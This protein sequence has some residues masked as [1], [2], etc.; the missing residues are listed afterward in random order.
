[1]CSFGLEFVNTVNICF[2]GGRHDVGVGTKTVVQLSV[3]LHLHV[4]L[5]HI[6]GA[7][8][9]GLDGKLFQRHLLHDDALQGL[10]GGID[11]TVA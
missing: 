4:H 5:A 2:Y 10:D 7:F 8:R 11:R 3:V 9:D 1:M 6:I